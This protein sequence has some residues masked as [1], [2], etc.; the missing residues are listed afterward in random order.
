MAA[1]AFDDLAVDIALWIDPHA[2]VMSGLLVGRHW[3]WED[4]DAHEI[5]NTVNGY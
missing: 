4:C 2:F 5:R 3:W 1:Q